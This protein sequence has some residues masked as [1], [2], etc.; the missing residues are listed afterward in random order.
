MKSRLQYIDKARGILISLMVIGHVWQSGFVFDTIYAFHMP[1]FFVISG[2]LMG[3][4]RSYQKPYPEFVK[5]RIAA[6]GIPFVFIELL[7]CMT[8]ILRNGVTLN[9]K[10]YLFNTLII[11]GTH[12]IIY[13]ALGKLL[14]VR[15]FAATPLHT[16]LLILLGVILLEIPTIYIINRWLPF[17][18]GKKRVRRS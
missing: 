11:Y 4:T 17:L 3:H 6:Y 18:A 16:G 1:A 7:G 8:D 9:W 13:A 10:G 15:D 2:I 5:S 14:G 12:H